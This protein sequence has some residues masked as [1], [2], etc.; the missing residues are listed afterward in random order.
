MNMK[1]IGEYLIERNLISR[2]Q[3]E[4]ALETQAGRIEGGH[5]PLIGT[6]L[7]EMGA[8]NEHDLNFALAEQER[9]RMRVPA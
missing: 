4:Q 9:D 2:A 8:V 3:L 6:I 5:M 7:V 1:K